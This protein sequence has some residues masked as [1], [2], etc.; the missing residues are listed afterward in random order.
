MTNIVPVI[1][2]IIGSLIIFLLGLLLYLFKALRQDLIDMDRKIDALSQNIDKKIEK[3][4][5][6]VDN[7]ME[8]KTKEI[9][10]DMRTR[11]ERPECI[12]EMNNLRDDLK[13]VTKTITNVATK[14]TIN[15]QELRKILR[16]IKENE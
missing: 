8:R 12:R 15:S 11:V 13:E 14:E 7:K 5:T 1:I 6:E 2:S 9:W 16:S 10:D 3:L 4:S